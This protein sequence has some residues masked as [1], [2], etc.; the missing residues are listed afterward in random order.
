M[1]E[2]EVFI[3][4]EIKPGKLVYSDTLIKGKSKKEVLLSTYLCHPQTANHELSGPIVW[5]TLYNIIKNTG[6]HYYSYR[7]LICPE[8]I[9]SAAFL[10]YSKKKVKDIDLILIKSLWVSIVTL[11]SNTLEPSLNAY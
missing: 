10:H 11:P 9:G 3:D 6:P 1:G 7:F 5:S 8:N 2:Y 4:S